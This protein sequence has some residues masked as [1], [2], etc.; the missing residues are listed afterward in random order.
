[1]TKK[2]ILLFPCLLLL[3][4][5]FTALSF[6]K[7][8]S[9][10][11]RIVT[12]KGEKTLEVKIFLSPYTYHREFKLYN[13]YRIGID[14]FDIKSIQSSRSIRVNALGIGAIRVSKFKANIARIVFDLTEEFPP[15]KTESFEEGL[16][17]VFWPE[18][19]PRVIP[20]EEPRVIEE[21][22]KIEDAICDIKVDPAKAN[23]NDPISV[24]ISGS[25]HAKSVEVDVFNPE[26]AK[27]DTQELTPDSPKWEIILDKPGE[28]VI[29]GKAF[30]MEGKPSENPCEVKTYIN[31]PPISKLECY[32]S[33]GNVGKSIAINASDSVD[34][35]GDV[36][37]VDF[38]IADEEGN[39]IDRF[40]DTE[41]PFS[42]VKVFKKKGIYTVTAIVTDDFGAVSEPAQVEFAAKQKRFFFLF[43]AGALAARG[44][45]T[46]IGYGAARAGVLY[47]IFPGTLDI[48][49][50]GGGAY[51]T[52][53]APWKPFYTANLLLNLHVGPV[54]LGTGAGFT[55]N[56]RDNQ[57]SKY[58]ELIVNLGFELFG[59]SKT[60]FSLFMETLGPVVDLSFKDNHKLMLGFRFLF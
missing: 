35:D 52:I 39:L 17:V 47:K 37:N 46:Y 14:L 59:G 24:D 51:T 50:S 18:E 55:T 60:S 11:E 49:L 19:E 20:E 4:L 23:I 16:R 54:F 15:Y 7:E 36:V 32:P 38:T 10:L 5:S 12:S 9:I 53:D 34:S 27:I 26:G 2:N 13:P 25:Q 29:K 45:G 22:I 1:M 41:K 30:N 56:A 3:V 8:E 42:W 21:K 48:I 57:S 33:K 43:D 40:V 6:S 31:F 28:Y 58:G 44:E